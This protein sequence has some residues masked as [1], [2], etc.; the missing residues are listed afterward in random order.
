MQKSSPHIEI[1]ARIAQACERSG[2]K[3]KEVQ[4]IWVSKT[5][6]IEAVEWAR[7]L[8]AK[9]F[10]ENRVQ[11][12]VEKFTTKPEGEELHIIGPLQTNKMRKAIQVAEWLHTVS[13]LKHL[14]ALQRICEEENRSIKVLFQVNTSGED[15]KSGIPLSEMRS[16]LG[17]LEPRSNLLYSGLMTIALNA[18]NP[19]VNRKEFQALKQLQTEVLNS[20]P[21]FSEFKELSM[22]MSGDFEVAVEEGATMIRIG[23]ALFGART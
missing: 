10:G 12:A 3:P 17:N 22:G 7:S 1:E 14:N 9:T 5:K 20:A 23:T 18:G 8:G 15:S 19:E 6:P 21:H 2:R 16:F 13:S 11:E 4:L